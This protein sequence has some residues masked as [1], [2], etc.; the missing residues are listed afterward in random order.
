MAK[1]QEFLLSFCQSTLKR[2][3]E[4]EEKADDDQESHDSDRQDVQVEY[5]QD[6][7]VE[8]SPEE[9]EHESEHSCHDPSHMMSTLSP[10]NFGDL[11]TPEVASH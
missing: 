1:R 10:Q 2:Q 8:D 11:S 5:H 4:S 9:S 6:I 3:R 7:Q